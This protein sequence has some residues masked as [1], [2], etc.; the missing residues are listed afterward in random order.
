[1]KFFYETSVDNFEA[2]SGAEPILARINDEGKAGE[3]ESILEEMFPDGMDEQQLNDMLW[4]DSETVFNWLGISGE[5][6]EGDD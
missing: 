2:W 5:T 4:F 3:L 1:M 6:D